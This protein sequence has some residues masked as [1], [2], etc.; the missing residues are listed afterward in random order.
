MTFHG[1]TGEAANGLKVL[2]CPVGHDA[3]V[4]KG[5]EEVAVKLEQALNIVNQLYNLQLRLALLRSCMAVCKVNYLLR[6]ADL[7]GCP[8]VVASWSNLLRDSIAVMCGTTLAD[9]QWQ[10]VR[11]PVA[12]GGL[13]GGCRLQTQAA[14]R[15]AALLRFRSAAQTMGLPERWQQVPL[16]CGRV[17]S[18]LSSECAG[19]IPML[20]ELLFASGWEPLEVE[21]KWLDQRAWISVVWDVAR[22][23]LLNSAE[24]R[25]LCRLRS[26]VFS[27]GWTC[28][29]PGLHMSSRMT[30]ADYRPHCEWIYLNTMLFMWEG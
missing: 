23:V 6:A 24:G 12:A 20:R 27:A 11:L 10:Q 16:D 28:V 19:T 7:S 18:A 29:L 15:M 3:F 4:R 30:K 5:M 21:D 13:G 8:D 1:S 17:T 14:A 25:D 22:L 9:H 26:Q 2:R